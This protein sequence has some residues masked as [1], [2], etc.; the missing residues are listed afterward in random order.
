MKM[1]GRHPSYTMSVTKPQI[2]EEARVANLEV[3]SW[4]WTLRGLSESVFV[5]MQKPPA[6][7]SQTIALNTRGKPRW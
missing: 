4:Q 5:V 6:D 3:H 1:V 7:R 2:L